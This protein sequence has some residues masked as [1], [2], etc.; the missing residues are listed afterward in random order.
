[1]TEGNCARGAER[2]GRRVVAIAETLRTSFGRDDGYS[3]RRI[4]GHDREST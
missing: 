2:R 1:M 4:S 3:A